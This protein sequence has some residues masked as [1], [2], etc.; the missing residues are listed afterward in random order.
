M[1][2][3]F[4][5][6]W[7]LIRRLALIGLLLGLVASWIEG[8]L[9]CAPANHPVV[10][11]KDLSGAPVTFPSGS[12]AKI[13]GWI[14]PGQTNRGVIV[15][16]HGVR[17]DKSTLLGRARFLSRAGYTVML[18]DFQAHGE[19]PGNVITFGYLESRDAVAAV[20]MVQKIFPGRPVGVIGISLGAAAAVLADPPLDVQ[21]M[22][23]EMMY[24]TIEEATKDRI[25]MRLGTPGR[26]IS[27]LLTAQIPGRAG[28]KPQD[29]RP[30][31]QVAFIKVPK[32][33]VAGTADRDT[34]FSEA[35]A[36]FTAA[37]EPKQ[38]M[39]V[40]GAAHEDLHDFNK[41]QYEKT[42]LAF[43]DKYLK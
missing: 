43:L 19:S 15:L 8:G 35:Q 39:P 42:V 2:Q 32:L 1:I 36:I 11:P 13:S 10:L 25:E 12:G 27:P 40:E 26:I 14:I 5:K 38:F 24:P 3:F 20:Q 29:L 23:L 21:A 37:A 17:A 6:K 4:K 16:M 22:V 34:K 9:L 30:I 31:N 7:T 18:F 33:F 28:C 41:A